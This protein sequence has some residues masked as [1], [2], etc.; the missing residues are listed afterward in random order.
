MNA[1]QKT[2]KEW[3]ATNKILLGL[4]GE[5]IVARYLR[6]R[7]HAVEESL[8]MFDSEKDLLCDGN[9][10]EVK[11]QVPIVVEDSFGVDPRQLP[12]LRESHRVYWVSVPL[13][14]SSDELAG[15]VFEM[16]PSDP[17]LKAHRWRTHAGREM[18]CFPRR[19]TAIREVYRVTDPVILEHLQRLSSSYL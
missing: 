4:L 16:D 19:Q 13:Q 9:K 2:K 5:R 6:S 7:G 12:K 14:K 8:D 18:V 10:V 15:A 3:V 11:T 17:T 1:P